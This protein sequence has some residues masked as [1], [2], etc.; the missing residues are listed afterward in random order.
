M[1]KIGI[2]NQPI[3]SIISGLG[4]TDKLVVA[5]AGLPIP[6]GVNRIDLALKEG[7]PSFLETLEVILSEMQV[8]SAIVASEIKEKNE[9]LEKKLIE[10]LGDT[11]I[12]YVAHENFKEETKSTRAI[13]RTGEFSPFANVILVSGVVF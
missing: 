1:K 10:L 9:K 6:A 13:I 4:H 2:I 5:D 8:E 7:I 11:P 3:A 12:E